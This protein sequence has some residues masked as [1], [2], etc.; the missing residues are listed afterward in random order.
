M[1]ASP[2]RKPPL[3][4]SPAVLA[5]RAGRWASGLSFRPRGPRDWLVVA[6][7]ALQAAAGVAAAWWLGRQMWAVHKLTRGVGDTMFF[8][9]DGKAWFPLDE[10]RRDVSLDQISPHLR[11]AVVAVED[12]RF[13]KHAGIDPI[14]LTRAAVRNVRSGGVV[15][16]V[17][18]DDIKMSEIVQT[19][20]EI[21]MQYNRTPARSFDETTPA[22]REISIRSSD[23]IAPSFSPAS[24][25][26][27]CFAICR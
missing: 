2:V 7:L 27:N 16:G 25:P 4:S 1:T 12:H 15:E 24:L 23:F 20:I 6:L 8:G 9:A 17:K 21:D 18:I 10:Q 26:Q 5:R 13:Y 3:T 19:A 14:G 11:H 22:V